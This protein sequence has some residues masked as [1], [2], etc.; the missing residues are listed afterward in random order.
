LSETMRYHFMP[1][2]EAKRLY[3]AVTHNVNGVLP[4][5]RMHW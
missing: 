1:E 2:S 4:W 3:E 5:I